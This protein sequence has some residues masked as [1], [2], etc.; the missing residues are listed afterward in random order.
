M[1]QADIQPLNHHSSG[2]NRFGFRESTSRMVK[3]GASALSIV[4]RGYPNSRYLLLSDELSRVLDDNPVDRARRSI[5]WRAGID[6]VSPLI[7]I[8]RD[9]GWTERDSE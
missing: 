8:S 2:L 4:E 3:L 7:G 9:P 1:D 6:R 5:R